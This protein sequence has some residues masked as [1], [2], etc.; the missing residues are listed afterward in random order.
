MAK[1]Y[2]LDQL[3]KSEAEKSLDDGKTTKNRSGVKIKKVTPERFC[4]NLAIHWVETYNP[5]KCHR[6]RYYRYVWM[7]DRK[8]HHKHIPGGNI[9]NPLALALKEE[10]EKAIAKGFSCQQV[11][12][13]LV[14]ASV[15][16]SSIN[17]D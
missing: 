13:L 8:M 7:D 15:P 3:I 12:H 14:A 2:S 5:S 10:V 1:K 11:I 6:Y 9:H 17:P 4:V 16:R